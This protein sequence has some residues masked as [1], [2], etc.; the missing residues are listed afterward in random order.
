MKTLSDLELEL[1]RHV[2]ASGPLT[3]REAAEGFGEP[4]GYARTTVS[5]LLERLREKRYLKRAKKDGVYVYSS[6]LSQG[7]L[8]RTVVGRFVDRALG[9]SVSPLVAFL[10]ENPSL[11]DRE[12]EELRRLVEGLGGKP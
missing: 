5:T 4:R 11:T 7:E 1:V 8:M 9:G 2:L 6:V 10:T 12:V 3:V